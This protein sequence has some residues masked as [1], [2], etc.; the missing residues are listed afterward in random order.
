MR[1]GEESRS[2]HW[3]LEREDSA[4]IIAMIILNNY[5][6]NNIVQLLQ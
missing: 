4:I 1:E 3:D 5:C 6:D 2:G